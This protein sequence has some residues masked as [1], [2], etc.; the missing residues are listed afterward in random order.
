MIAP[1]MSFKFRLVPSKPPCELECE[2]GD[3]TPGPVLVLTVGEEDDDDD[4][5]NDDDAEVRAIV[6]LLV[7]LLEV[8]GALV[9][10][11]LPV[12]SAVV[13]AVVCDVVCAAV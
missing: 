13:S 8:P 7:W 4:E 2:G 11:E 6:L 3:S 5:D 1:T 9:G 12:V 10:D